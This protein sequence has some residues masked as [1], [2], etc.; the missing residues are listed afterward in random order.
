MLDEIKEEL[1][2]MESLE[3][4]AV[5]CLNYGM[6]HSYSTVIANE[7]AI[8]FHGAGFGDSSV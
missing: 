6:L 4:F 1:S 5:H 3:W 8:W 2:R 7:K